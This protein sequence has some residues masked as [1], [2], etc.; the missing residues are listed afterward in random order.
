MFQIEVPTDINII[1]YLIYPI[2]YYHSVKKAI[3][4]LLTITKELLNTVKIYLT[5]GVQSKNCFKVTWNS[6][7]GGYVTN[8][9][10]RYIHL[11]K[12][13]SNF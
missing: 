8:L 10:C 4:I 2:V 11:F 1:I 3:P 12:F 9:V 13:V 6:S 7:L 5:R